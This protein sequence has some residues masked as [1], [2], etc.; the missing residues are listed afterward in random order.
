MA[1]PQLSAAVTTQTQLTGRVDD[2]YIQHRESSLEK[3]LIS[4]AVLVAQVSGAM[5]E[6]C[7]LF[8]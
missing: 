1:V 8:H 3:V 2:R 6:E 4:A 5:F 7:V